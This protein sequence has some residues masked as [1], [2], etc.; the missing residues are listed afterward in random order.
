MSE[1]LGGLKNLTQND[2][3]V[4][5]YFKAK[6]L[7]R[8]QRKW[9][10]AEID[11]IAQI[12]RYQNLAET[13]RKQLAIVDLGSRYAWL[14]FFVI[15]GASLFGYFHHHLF[16]KIPHNFAISIIFGLSFSCFL[17][18]VL[19]GLVIEKILRKK[20]FQEEVEERKEAILEED[21]EAIFEVIQIPKKDDDF[22]WISLQKIKGLLENERIF[23]AQNSKFLAALLKNLGFEW[24]RMNTG[25]HFKILRRKNENFSGNV[26]KVKQKTPTSLATQLDFEK[27]KIKGGEKEQNPRNM[28]E[29]EEKRRRGRE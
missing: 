15:G 2:L 17:N 26:A 9:S 19:T 4:V 14:W 23:F 22:E 18:V 8:F 7:N 5:D 21:G 12:R 25:L 20:A 3:N 6:E 11:A 24:K 13:Y 29:N 28:R 10:Y 1:N 27:G 16:P